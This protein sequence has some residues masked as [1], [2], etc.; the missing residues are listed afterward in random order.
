M[1][2]FN[3]SVL[4]LAMVVT[5]VYADGVATIEKVEIEEGVTATQELS[6]TRDGQVIVLTADNEV[7]LNDVIDTDTKKVL[8]KMQNGA[9]WGLDEKTKFKVVEYQGNKVVYELIEA[10]LAT[11]DAG[12]KAAEAIIRINKRDYTA[13]SDAQVEF[14]YD[15]EDT[16]VVVLAGTVKFAGEVVKKDKTAKI[17]AQG[18]VQINTTL[19]TRG[20]RG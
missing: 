18:K 19:K 6:V 1:K 4:L 13:S 17:D 9:M 11:Y 14:S 10:E 7:K 3:L 16:T 12:K 20:I 5:P 8:L 15:N 2:K